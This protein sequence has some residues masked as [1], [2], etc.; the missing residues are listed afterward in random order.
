MQLRKYV[1]YTWGP[2]NMDV[3]NINGKQHSSSRIDSFCGI[4]SMRKMKQ[5]IRMDSLHL[6]MLPNDSNDV[7]WFFS[8]YKCNCLCFWSSAICLYIEDYLII[9][10][11][12]RW[13]NAAQD[14]SLSGKAKS[15]AVDTAGNIH[16]EVPI[17]K[18]KHVF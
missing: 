1:V 3:K 12:F 18:G 16:T 7:V 8:N 11:L 2:T 4:G 6:D 15:T 10:F 13:K 17:S 14:A 9:S 5:S